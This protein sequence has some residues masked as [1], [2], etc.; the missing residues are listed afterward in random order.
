MTAHTQTP[1]RPALPTDKLVLADG[2]HLRLRDVDSRDRDGFAA[3]FYRLSPASRLSRFLSPKRELTPREID[4]FTDIDQFHHCAIAAVEERGSIVAISR[5][6]AHPDDPSGRAELAMEVA[7]ELQAKGIGAALAHR[8][9]QRA[10]TNG[11]N[12][13]TATI[14]W[15]NQSA[16]RLLERL[17]FNGRASR[18]TIEYELQLT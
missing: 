14:S 18:G 9:V 16:R 10:R 2:M 5:Y 12:G 13:L 8:T 15:D 11:F 3:F 7:D 6:V 17:G 1:A 4:Y